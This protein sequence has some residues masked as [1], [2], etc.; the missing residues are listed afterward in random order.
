M[1]V[2][3]MC[4]S[5]QLQRTY[6]IGGPTEIDSEGECGSDATG[7]SSI[8]VVLMQQVYHPSKE[9]ATGSNYFTSMVKVTNELL[10][11]SATTCFPIAPFT[12]KVMKVD[13]FLWWQTQFPSCGVN[14]DAQEGHTSGRAF[15]L[16]SSE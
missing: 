16:M 9:R 13:E 1:V 10:Q 12:Q 14:D 8:V 5:I 2:C 4:R 11:F 6:T 3:T 15:Q 7:L